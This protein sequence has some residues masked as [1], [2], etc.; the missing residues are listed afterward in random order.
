M[1]SMQ[2]DCRGQRLALFPTRPVRPDRRPDLGSVDVE[3]PVTQRYC[4]DCGAV[5]A[6][7]VTHISAPALMPAEPAALRLRLG[8]AETETPYSKRR[9]TMKAFPVLTF[10]DALP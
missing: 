7:T 1:L 5:F 10:F 9:P 8:V 3:W 4:C 2:F 6:P